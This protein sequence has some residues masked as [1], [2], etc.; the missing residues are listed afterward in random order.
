[1]LSITFGGFLTTLAI[2]KAAKLDDDSLYHVVEDSHGN[3]AQES[4]R[5]ESVATCSEIMA[6]N[7]PTFSL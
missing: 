5:K 3:E 7:G 6:R 2:A 1:M 4:S